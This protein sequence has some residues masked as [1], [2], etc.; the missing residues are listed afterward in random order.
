MGESSKKFFTAKPQDFSI[1]IFKHIINKGVYEGPVCCHG[2]KIG[3]AKPKSIYKPPIKVV[4]IKD[5]DDDTEEDV[6][7]ITKA[8]EKTPEEKGEYKNE[9]CN[10]FPRIPDKTFVE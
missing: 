10:C 5:E 9:P 2:N 1:P 7:K 3:P 8:D 6:F 4:E